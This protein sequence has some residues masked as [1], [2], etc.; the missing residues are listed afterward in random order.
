MSLTSWVFI[1][2][3]AL[4]L[5]ELLTLD[6]TLLMLALGTY[7]AAVA[8]SLG[9]NGLVAALVGVAVAVVSLGFLRPLALRMFR[10]GTRLPTG[11]DALLGATGVVVR[12]IGETGG[13]VK[14]RGEVWSARS[15]GG[16][17]IAEGSTVDVVA[18][19][20]ATAV[21]VARTEGSR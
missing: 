8:L 14:L 1:A 4:V 19:E 7:A 13:Q 10:K 3:S 2:G 20:G 6:F 9:A 17:A 18:I 21:V 12:A 5:L 16:S 15:H 11:T